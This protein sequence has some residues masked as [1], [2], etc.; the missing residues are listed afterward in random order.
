MKSTITEGA[1]FHSTALGETRW[2]VRSL[3]GEDA[4]NHE[5]SFRVRLELATATF[6]HE[7]LERVLDAPATLSFIEGDLELNRFSG[8]VAS[9]TARPDVE[10]TRT[11]L[12][13]TLVPRTAL[14]AHWRGSELFL[15]RTIPEVL[16]EKLL[17]W[18]LR[19]GDDFISLLRAKYFRRELVAQ[20]E[21]SDLAFVRRLC[22]GSGIT[23]HFEERGGHE[24]LVLSDGNTPFE[25]I[26]RPRLHARRRADH[27]AAYDIETTL[28]RV[29]ANVR[30]HDYNYRTPMLTLVD[31]ERT[32]RAAATG[33]WNEFGE[34]PKTR[35]DVRALVV[36]RQEELAC[37]HHTITGYAT[38]AGLRAGRVVHIVDSVASEQALLLTRVHYRFRAEANG[39]EDAQGWENRFEGVPANVAYRPPRVTPVPKIAGLMNA[40]IDGAIRGD[41][42]ELDDLGRYRLQLAPDRS[43]RTDLGATHPVRMMQPHGGANYGMPIP[44]L[45]CGIT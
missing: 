14:A 38:E 10:R 1:L 22:E 33:E 37:K 41:Y 5:Y 6:T 31:A 9:L 20:H 44:H 12:E 27:P 8:V 34:H 13:L 2:T 15:E 35:D 40:V 23:T 25:T 3:E 32:Q 24:V 19:E 21:E 39:S 29:P 7:D 17:S 11:A 45:T 16:F 43:G 30:L 28:R 4:L 18:G 26:G 42:A 36:T